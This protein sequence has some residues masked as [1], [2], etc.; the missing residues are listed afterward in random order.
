MVLNNLFLDAWT[1]CFPSMTQRD[2][3]QMDRI[4]SHSLHSALRHLIRFGDTV[5]PQTHV[6][7][8]Y[9]RVS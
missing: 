7:W 2:W 1:I 8:P 5:F 6:S 9:M 4:D 3:R